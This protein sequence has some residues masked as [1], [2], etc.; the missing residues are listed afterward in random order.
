MAQLVD[1]VRV[2]RLYGV[3]GKRFGRVHRMVANSASEALK[4]LC[5]LVPG[6]EQF[7][8]CSKDMGITYSVFIGAE[9]IDRERLDFPVGNDD[10]RIAPIVIGSKR[11][12]VFQTILGVVL[13]IASI[14]FQPLLPM[15]LAML[16]GGVAALLSPQTKGLSAEDSVNN[17][18]SYT[19]N[20]AVNTS[21]QGNP[22]PVFYGEGFSG[23]AVIS[24]G[25]FAEDQ[26]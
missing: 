1:R 6:F 7:L 22:V 13:L 12:G 25:I 10:I 4:A 5:I 24:A 9:N 11:A 2:V 14:W 18:A 21:A 15:A 3:L 20:G 26:K 23:S 16:A 8:T 19:F 17:R